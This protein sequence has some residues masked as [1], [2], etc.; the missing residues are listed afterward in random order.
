LPSPA[1]RLP[2]SH[3][4]IKQSDCFLWPLIEQLNPRMQ[5][6]FCRLSVAILVCVPSRMRFA[7]TLSC[8]AINNSASRRRAEYRSADRFRAHDKPEWLR[9]LDRAPAAFRQL[10]TRQSPLRHAVVI[11]DLAIQLERFADRFNAANA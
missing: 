3:Q 5:Q 9:R 1:I 2:V 10:R 7:M 4:R 8:F 11:R 6:A